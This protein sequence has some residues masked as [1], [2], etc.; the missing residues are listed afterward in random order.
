LGA[1]LLCSTDPIAA[2]AMADKLNQLNEERRDIE[3]AVRLSAMNKPNS[4]GLTVRWFG[5]QA[6]AGTPVWWAS[7]HRA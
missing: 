1:K 4:A 6:M 5:Q 7:S 2:Q 3:Q